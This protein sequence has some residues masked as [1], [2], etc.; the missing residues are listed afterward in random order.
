MKTTHSINKLGFL[1][2]LTLLGFF[3][4]FTTAGMFGFFGFAY[5][6]RYFF[7]VPDELFE[8]NVRK[9]AAYGFFSGIA[10]TAILM[11]AHLL[12]PAAISGSIALAA[13]FV[14]SVAVFTL[15]LGFLEG[16]ERAEG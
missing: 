14:A 4:F 7:V 9:S 5:Y 6:A 12:F 3:G 2:L 15:T 1:A 13:C 8:Q 10:A 16:R 11:A